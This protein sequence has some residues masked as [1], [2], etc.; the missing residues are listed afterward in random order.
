MPGAAGRSPRSVLPWSCPA[1]AAA[2]PPRAPQPHFPTHSSCIG[3]ALPEDYLAHRSHTATPPTL[4]VAGF[5]AL[6]SVDATVSAPA[7]APGAAAGAPMVTPGMLVTDCIAA[8]IAI[9]CASAICMHGAQAR[10][11]LWEGC[12]AVCHLHARATT[13][14][15]RLGRVHGT[16][17]A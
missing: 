16:T 8:N 3:R 10:G 17:H 13:E 12:M 14:G 15:Q 6:G 1:R 5:G 7:A 11:S 9:R 4:R 2:R